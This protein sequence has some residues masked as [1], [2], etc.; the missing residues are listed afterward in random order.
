MIEKI[1]LKLLKKERLIATLLSFVLGA[2][3]TAL[4]INAEVVKQEFCSSK[5]VQE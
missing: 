4:G 5:Y 1:L 3:A 2:S